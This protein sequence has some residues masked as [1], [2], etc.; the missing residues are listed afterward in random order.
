MLGHGKKTTNIAKALWLAMAIKTSLWLQIL[1][2]K[3]NISDIV[4]ATLTFSL[5]NE[6]VKTTMTIL[7]CLGGLRWPVTCFY[8][9]LSIGFH[10]LCPKFTS[11]SYQVRSRHP[12]NGGIKVSRSK[13]RGEEKY[14]ICLN[15]WC[16]TVLLILAKKQKAAF[17]P[18]P[19]V[20][21]S[22]IISAVKH[23][24]NNL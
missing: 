18:S 10:I 16:P 2:S 11:F 9:Q 19:I 24:L 12:E 4:F 8:R 7:T 22:H 14:H 23:L 3:K 5:E 17:H 21:R 13:S 20:C 15:I 6:L 1:I